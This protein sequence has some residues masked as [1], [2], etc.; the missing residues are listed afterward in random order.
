MA[1]LQYYDHTHIQGISYNIYGGMKFSCAV[2]ISIICMQALT[3]PIT[4]KLWT[5]E[6]V[7]IDNCGQPSKL[8]VVGFLLQQQEHIPTHGTRWVWLGRGLELL[9]SPWDAI[10]DLALYFSVVC[11]EV[12]ACVPDHLL[13][14]GSC[15]IL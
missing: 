8:N 5:I 7:T 9:L 3:I 10:S 6:S 4:C 1:W 12:Q 15:T 13:C 11:Q 2:N 14:R